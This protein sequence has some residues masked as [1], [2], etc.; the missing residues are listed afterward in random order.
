[1]IESI[2]RVLNSQQIGFFKEKRCEFCQNYSSLGICIFDEGNV[3]D[4]IINCIEEELFRVRI[5]IVRAE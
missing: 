4:A 1:M 2:T 5:D 3:S